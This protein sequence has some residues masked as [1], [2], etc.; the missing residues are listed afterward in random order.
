[1][2]ELNLSDIEIR[3]MYLEKVR[4]DKSYLKNIKVPKLLT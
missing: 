2:D 3:S 1:M 4:D